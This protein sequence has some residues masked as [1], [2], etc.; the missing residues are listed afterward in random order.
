MT[1][2]MPSAE[3]ASDEPNLAFTVGTAALMNCCST[4]PAGPLV[5]T[6]TAPLAGAETSLGSPAT[7]LS[8]GTPMARV[9]PSA[10]K[11]TLSPRKAFAVVLK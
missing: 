5:N 9:L 6:S 7:L 1:M 8:L 10:D 3:M 11:T 4:Q 2:R